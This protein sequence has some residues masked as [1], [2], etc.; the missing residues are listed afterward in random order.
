MLT[1]NLFNLSPFVREQWATEKVGTYLSFLAEKGEA[2]QFPTIVDGLAEEA[3]RAGFPLMVRGG[4][5]VVSLMGLMMRRAGPFARLFGITGT[6]SIRLAMQAALNDPDVENVVLRI[7]SPGGSVSGLDQLADTIAQKTK[8][9]IAVVEGV[10][11]SAAYYVASQADRILVGRTDLVGSIGTRMLLYD[12][13]KAFENEGIKA[14]PIDTGEHKSAGAM[15][16]EIT[17][18]QIAEFQKL[19][20]FYFE[21]FVGIV[22]KGRRLSSTEV[23]KVADGRMFPPSEAIAL[24]LVDD[25]G[26]LQDVLGALRKKKAKTE[27]RRRR[28]A[29]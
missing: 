14:I 6:D 16:T 23:L 12:F 5:A 22:A 3:E 1:D 17:E 20:D 28:L 13:S 15:G 27:S 2:D 24:G 29:V 10:A 21:D 11:A 9:V 19:V 18:A 25:V 26:T 8:P 7:D 4:T